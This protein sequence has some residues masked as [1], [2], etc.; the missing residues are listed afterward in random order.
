MGKW[1]TSKEAP[2]HLSSPRQRRW[3]QEVP[4]E[5]FPA[6]GVGVPTV[7][8]WRTQLHTWLP[9]AENLLVWGLWE[10]DLCRWAWFVF[11]YTA[12]YFLQEVLSPLI[13]TS[14]CHSEQK[15]WS[16][17]PLPLLFSLYVQRERERI[18]STETHGS[19]QLHLMAEIIPSQGK[20]YRPN[21]G[22]SLEFLRPVDFG[23]PGEH[24]QVP[25]VSSEKIRIDGRESHGR[26]EDD[27]LSTVCGY[28]A[29]CSRP[30]SWLRD[31]LAKLD[32][33]VVLVIAAMSTGLKFITCH[34]MSESFPE[35]AS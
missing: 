13:T 19:F 5:P 16:T 20:I 8:L 27:V 17:D 29:S 1:K 6:T 14:Y 21:E 7:T 26:S 2:G 32:L 24:Q 28:A 3:P 4:G 10:W 23:Q 9:P 22:Y 18:L 25:W 35:T 11:F 12:F 30:C 31:G 33:E 34:G 15:L